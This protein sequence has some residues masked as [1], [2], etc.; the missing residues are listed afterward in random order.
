[1][2]YGG[3]TVTVAL[4]LGVVGFACIGGREVRKQVAPR[5]IEQRGNDGLD[6]GGRGFFAIEPK[7][8]FRIVYVEEWEQTVGFT[9]NRLELLGKSFASPPQRFAVALTKIIGAELT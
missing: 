6:I 7:T 3:D 5:L 8:E 9:I 4:R 1:V 2:A